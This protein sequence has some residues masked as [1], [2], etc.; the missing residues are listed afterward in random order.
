M[1]QTVGMTLSSKNE[2]VVGNCYG[3]ENADAWFPTTYNGGRPN[4]MFRNLLP[5]IQYALDKCKSCPLK[6]N[7]LEEGMRPMNL[8]QGIWGGKFA[9]ERIL[10]ARERDMNYIVP[11]ANRGRVLGPRSGDVYPVQ[12]DGIT[13]QEEEDAILFHERVVRYLG[14]ELEGYA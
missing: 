6:E 14:P 11:F 12:A 13:M 3:D 7:C 10:M 4:V 2:P 1:T 5:D 9:G 8:A